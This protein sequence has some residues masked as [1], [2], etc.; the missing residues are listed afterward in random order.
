MKNWLRKKRRV[1]G[2]LTKGLID[3]APRLAWLLLLICLVWG[4]LWFETLYALNM[5]KGKTELELFAL[6]L[7]LP[8]ISVAILVALFFGSLLLVIIMFEPEVGR[9]GAL[10]YSMKY[11]GDIQLLKDALTNRLSASNLQ[12]R[13]LSFKAE[14]SY[15]LIARWSAET[16]FYCWLRKGESQQGWHCLLIRLQ[17]IRPCLYLPKLRLSLHPR[18]VEDLLYFKEA[19]EAIR[20]AGEQSRKRGIISNS[21]LATVEPHDMSN[22]KG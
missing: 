17:A 4:V 9:E 2:F 1:V 10:K 11:E 5:G 8:T 6:A 18:E 16:V 22:E 19:L 14:A 20:W 3:A 12:C 13:W 21:D 7:T 15:I